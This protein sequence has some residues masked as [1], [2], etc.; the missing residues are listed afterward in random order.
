MLSVFTLLGEAQAPLAIPRQENALPI[1]DDHFEVTFSGG[2]A[3]E[4][5]VA[6]SVSRFLSADLLPLVFVEIGD[7]ARG[8]AERD[9]VAVMA[10]VG[11]ES[12]DDL[13]RLADVPH[14]VFEFEYVDAGDL[15]RVGEQRGS[16]PS[17]RHV[18][19]M[20]ENGRNGTGM[21]SG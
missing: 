4:I 7:G 1:L 20:K 3:G 12:G 21:R 16:R 8:E 13:T 19:A 14:L 9:D 2:P 15:R 5:E 18:I 17:L 10:T 11:R 6:E